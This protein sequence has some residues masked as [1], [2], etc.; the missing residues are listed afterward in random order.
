MKLWGFSALAH[1]RQTIELTMCITSLGSCHSYL[2]A[3]NEVFQVVF[4]IR[5]L[6]LEMFRIAE[7]WATDYVKS[8]QHERFQVEPFEFT[9]LD[10]PSFLPPVAQVS[11]ILHFNHR[12]HFVELKLNAGDISSCDLGSETDSNRVSITRISEEFRCGLLGGAKLILLCRK[13]HLLC[14]V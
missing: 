10:K 9:I 4:K 13:P 3:K 14:D 5:N 12:C 6:C 11:T 8:S 1:I 2:Q 7:S